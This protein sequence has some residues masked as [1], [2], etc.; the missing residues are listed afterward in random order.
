MDP[1][2]RR[3]YYFNSD[4]SEVVWQRPEELRGISLGISGSAPPPPKGAPT[5]AAPTPQG[6]AAE[7]SQ[8]AAEYAALEKEWVVRTPAIP[9]TT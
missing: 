8:K 2:R 4:T 7:A 6:A 9:T 5:A 1:M 3:P